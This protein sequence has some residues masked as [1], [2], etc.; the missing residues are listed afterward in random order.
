MYAIILIILYYIDEELLSFK[1]RKDNSTITSIFLQHI[2]PKLRAG[3]DFVRVGYSF[4]SII[5]IEL[6]RK[7]EAR[8]F[9]DRLI[10]VNGAPEQMRMMHEDFVSDS[11]DVDLHILLLMNIMKIYA[12]ESS[13]KVIFSKIYI[14][15]NLRIFMC[16]YIL[17]IYLRGISI[18]LFP[19]ISYF[20]YFLFWKK[21]LYKNK[22]YN[23]T[24]SNGIEEM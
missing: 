4:G 21:T 13:E 10:L 22:I 19:L 2:L 12:A 23:F 15:I 9:K 7:L 5:A 14:K 16:L 17:Y 6:I 20:K 24:D 3:K 1:R 18:N 8:N 11:N